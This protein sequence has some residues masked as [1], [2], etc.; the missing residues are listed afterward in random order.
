MI[1]NMN[2][3][4]TSHGHPC[5]AKVTLEAKPFKV[6]RCG[7]VSVCAVCGN[8]AGRIHAEP[9]REKYDVPGSEG[10]I[11]PFP[12]QYGS[13][14]VY[15]RD[16]YSGVGNCMCGHP[17]GADRHVEAAPGVPIPVRLR[18]S[19]AKITRMHIVTVVE[20]RVRPTF[21]STERSLGF[22]AKCSCGW[23]GFTESTER[24]A[25]NAHNIHHIDVAASE[26][27]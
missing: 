16:V 7:G 11:G 23:R 25:L 14:H 3:E 26:L 10:A 12:R 1:D 22:R 8:D 24:E 6:H 20:D 27:R 9:M 13:P 5:C 17:L 2:H 4:W 19:Y 18:A 15:A 21:F